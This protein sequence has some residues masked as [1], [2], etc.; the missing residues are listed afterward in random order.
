V[1]GIFNVEIVREAL[2]KELFS[3]RALLAKSSSFPAVEGARSFNLENL[4]SLLFIIAG[5][6][7]ADTEGTH[8]A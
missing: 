2:L 4:G 3:L 6:N 5:N 7:H 8:S 1:N